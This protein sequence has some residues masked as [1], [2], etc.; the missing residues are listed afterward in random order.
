LGPVAEGFG[1]RFLQQAVVAM[2]PAEQTVELGDGSEV[3]YDAAVVCVGA[4]PR[5]AFE[6]ATTFWAPGEQLEIDE[7]LRDSAGREP[8]RIAFVVPPGATWPL[9][10]YELALMGR[11]RAQELGLGNLECVIVT[12]ESSPLVVFGPV[13][14][15]SVAALLSGRGIQVRSGAWASEAE[16]GSLLLT[17]A[18]ERLEVSGVLA[19][20]I[21]DG[22]RMPGLPADEHGFIP[23]DD[24]AR[25]QGVER[26]YAAGDG[27]NF[28]IKQGGLGTQEADAAAAHIAA[29]FGAPV[30]PEP[31]QPVLR[32][33]LLTGDDSLNLRSNV[34]GGAGE[35]IASPDYLWWPPHKVSG[36]YLGAWLAGRVSR[37]DPEPPRLPLDV[38]VALPREWHRE[39]MALDLYGPPAV[40]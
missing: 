13:A 1:A 37:P 38:E 33:K 18:H 28:P 2:Q 29:S 27:T 35:G 12:P 24:H 34:A 5:S 21:L 14:S 26:V 20:P 6:S 16:D 32:G 39:P 31:F 40:E 36:R 4:R 7:L 9:P 17:P 23:I 3:G 15:G 8:G 19:L 10:L 30:D 22:P 11:R 25:V